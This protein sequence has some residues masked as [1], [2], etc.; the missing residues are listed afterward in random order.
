MYEW[1][2]QVLRQ[3]LDNKV[4]LAYRQWHLSHLCSKRFN[5][6]KS[7]KQLTQQIITWITQVAL[8]AW[9]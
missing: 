4:I 7:C 6:E 5:I 3:C 8:C 1:Y 9:H 2:Y